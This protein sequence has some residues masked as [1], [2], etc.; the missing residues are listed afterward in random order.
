MISE[1]AKPQLKGLMDLRRVS[2]PP[3]KYLPESLMPSFPANSKRQDDALKENHL[4]K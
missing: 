3:K 2:T 1:L 4:S